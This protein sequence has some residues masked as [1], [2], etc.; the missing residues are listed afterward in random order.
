MAVFQNNAITNNGKDLL[1][2]VQ[3]GAVFTPTAIKLGTGYIP[4]GKNA[5]TMTNLVSAV[6]SLVVV[7]KERTNDG[8][9]IIGGIYSNKDISEDWYFRELG[10]YAKAVYPDGT[11]VAEC[12]YSYG[13]S[14]DTAE[15]MHAYAS[16]QPVERQIDIV[17]WV[18]NDTAIDLTIAPSIPVLREQL[19]V[20]NGVAMLNADGILT[21]SQRPS[22]TQL[23]AFPKIESPNDLNGITQTCATEIF[24]DTKNSPYHLGQTTATHGLC[25]TSYAGSGYALQFALLS[26]DSTVYVRRQTGGYW[27]TKWTAQYSESFK[28]SLLSL[29]AAQSGVGEL[30]QQNLLGWASAQGLSCAFYSNPSIT[31]AGL[32]ESGKWFTGWLSVAAERAKTIYAIRNDT[33]DIYVNVTIDGVWSEWTQLAS[34][35]HLETVIG[36][37]TATVE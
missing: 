7:K 6:L 20:P 4:T 2:H 35:K 36:L 12:L 27:D 1:S 15:L 18:G 14:G 3:A 10:L 26:G 29:G 11:E 37:V 9:V 24:G 16:G 8:K 32:P 21:E 31:T 33:G 5:K 34:T 23:G 17:T 28:P 13:N 25:F 30:T 19:G 22:A